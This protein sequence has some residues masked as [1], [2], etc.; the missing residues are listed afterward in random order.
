MHDKI[1]WLDLESCLIERILR[2]TNYPNLKALGLYNI[3]REMDTSFFTGKM[4]HV[5][6]VLEYSSNI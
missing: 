5:D 1:K 2:A 4:F 3:R 6:S